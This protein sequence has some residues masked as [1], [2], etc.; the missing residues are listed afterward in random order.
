[1]ETCLR[2][3]V[4]WYYNSKP[5]LLKSKC[6]DLIPYFGN[7]IFHI[8]FDFI[9]NSFDKKFSVSYYMTDD[10]HESSVTQG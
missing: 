6:Y 1:M 10:E 7:I 2:C 3:T 8:Y 4:I 5:A 9:I